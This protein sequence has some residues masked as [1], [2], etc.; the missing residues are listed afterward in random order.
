MK[1]DQ[2]ASGERRE[3]EEHEPNATSDIEQFNDPWWLPSSDRA[4]IAL[5]H[6]VRLTAEVADN[7][8]K[9]KRRRVDQLR[10]ERQIAAYVCDLW[11]RANASLGD[12]I[13]VSRSKGNLEMA[14]GRY[15][16]RELTGA[17]VSVQDALVECGL[18][19]S[20]PGEWGGSH[21]QGRR[22]TLRAK[23][24]L[25]DLLRE[26]S[27]EDLIRD[28]MEEV[29]LLRDEKADLTDYGQS[30][31]KPGKLI[32]YADDA[33][34][35]RMRGDLRAIND[36]LEKA[37]ITLDDGVLEAFTK[38]RFDPSSRRLYRIFA[39]GR[40][41]NGG[42][43]Y[44]GFWIGLPS[45]SRHHVLQI[46]GEAIT[47]LD[48][49]QMS[50]RLAYGRMGVRP[51]SGDLYAVGELSSW[52]REGV[53]KLVNAALFSSAPLTMRP[54]GTAELLPL[55]SIADLMTVLRETH[56][57]IAALFET[58]EGLRIQ[59]AESDIMCEVLLRLMG[60][61]ITALPIHDA[62]I[63]GEPHQLKAQEVM[64]D[65]FRE[66]SGVEAAVSISDEPDPL[67]DG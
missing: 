59:R 20:L 50:A 38:A 5:A 27:P 36:H 31:E 60:S 49:G 16:H 25:L 34:T 39:N 51:P 43:L 18:C 28:P 7:G 23:P 32:N 62:V 65:V 1:V 47:I 19:E 42:R 30:R 48:Y 61:G 15:D 6:A 4:K 26:T 52:R 3:A 67:G 9:R 66:M 22:T 14:K 41:D 8:R 55:G 63:V 57:S 58:G 2:L 46:D 24:L 54:R 10:F 53:K 45:V 29:I 44:R 56:A 11:H 21:G 35:Q 40:F 64:K 17:A 33:D 13:I 37:D 12:T